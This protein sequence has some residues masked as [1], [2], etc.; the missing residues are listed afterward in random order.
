LVSQE[1]VELARR[2][3]EN[4]D[5]LHTSPERIDRAFR[6]QVTE[7]FEFRLPP[8]Y[9]EGELV[10]RGRGGIDDLIALLRETWRE[11]RFEPEKFLDADDQVVVLG[12]I[13]GQGEASG[14]PVELETTHVVSVRRD[15]AI[16]IQV[17][18]DRAEALRATGLRS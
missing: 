12:R 16:S 5:L 10:F 3:Y 6:D 7:D 9:P 1:N 18:R 14:A 4:G 2:I 8:D 11:W 15:R 17:Y 13:V